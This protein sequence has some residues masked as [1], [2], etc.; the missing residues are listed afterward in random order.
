MFNKK[1]IFILILL[2]LIVI[3]F[4]FAQDNSTV[5]LGDDNSYSNVYFD[6]SLAQ[7]NGNGSK[8]NPYKYLNS[9]RISSNSNLYFAEG[10]YES[11]NSKVISSNNS[12][13]GENK[14]NTIITYKNS[15]YIFSNSGVL[16]LY[17]L[18]IK[19]ASIYNTGILKADN[20]IFK[21]SSN[22][23]YGGSIYSFLLR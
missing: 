21:D 14:E 19:S 22:Q 13:I 2:G 6:A 15:D 16:G 5:T 4:T 18:T 7:D 3:P 12:F 1:I 11:D 23:N 20:V 17:N 10:V 9:N 8:D